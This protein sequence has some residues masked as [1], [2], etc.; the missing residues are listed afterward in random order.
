MKSYESESVK[1]WI[2]LVFRAVFWPPGWHMA[3]FGKG[4]LKYGSTLNL[5]PNWTKLGHIVRVI[6][7]MTQNKG[8]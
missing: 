3:I 4:V 8:G 7:K 5:G 6:N 1:L 2:P